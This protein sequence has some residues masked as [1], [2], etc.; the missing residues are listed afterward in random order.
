VFLDIARVREDNP[1]RMDWANKITMKL[2]ARD[3]ADLVMGVRNA[4]SVDIFHKVNK[5][6]GSTPSTTLKVEPGTEGT[7]KWFVGKTVGS[8]KKFATIYLDQKDMYLTFQMLEAALPV[9]HGWTA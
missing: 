7:F 2:N 4:G 8:D 5:D 6:D 9:I 1:D 3:I